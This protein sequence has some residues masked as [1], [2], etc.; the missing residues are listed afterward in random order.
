MPD[1]DVDVDVDRPCLCHNH[2]NKP[3]IDSNNNNG[4]PAHSL[5]CRVSHLFNPEKE[6]CIN[7]K[8]KNLE[9][10]CHA[11]CYNHQHPTVS[12]FKVAGLF[13]HNHHLLFF[14]FSFFI[15]FLPYFVFRLALNVFNGSPFLLP[16]LKPL[17]GRPP[18]LCRLCLLSCLRSGTNP[19]S[20]DVNAFL[21]SLGSR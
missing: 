7:K 18:F 6:I 9:A 10:H 14:F 8:E 5:Q 15:Y 16:A 21:P 3:R 13:I 2:R 4:Y 12:N 19:I 11:P 1:A 20:S 17:P